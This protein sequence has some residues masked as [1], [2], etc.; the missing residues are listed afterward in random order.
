MMKKK[1]VFILKQITYWMEN[2]LYPY[3]LEEFGDRRLSSD[4]DGEIKWKHL[5]LAFG[6]IFLLIIISPLMLILYWLGKLT[7]KIQEKNHNP[8]RDKNA[9][10]FDHME[11]RWNDIL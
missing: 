7:D 5:C 10:Y 11:G 6:L 8:K 3:M 2:I 1:L 9:L 4:I